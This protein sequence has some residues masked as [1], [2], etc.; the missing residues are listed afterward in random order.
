[1]DNIPNDIIP[2]IFNFIKL[3]TDKRQFLRTCKQINN[4]TK[5]LMIECENKFKIDNFKKRNKY[6]VEKFTLELCHDKYFNLIPETYLT[7]NNKI[8][9]S[10]LATFGNLQ[11]LQIAMKNGC[12]LYVQWVSNNF[13][14]Y[15][16]DIPK[17]TDFATIT[18]T[19]ALAAHNGHKHIIEFCI[20]NG[21][22]VNRL[23]Y[24]MAI[25]N[26]HLELANWILKILENN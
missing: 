9:V 10:T 7:P 26:K 8:I 15:I 16:T 19:C 14:R 13:Y 5:K 4:I 18:D 2:I 12:K 1:M 22:K 17:I 21:G 6:C 23:S 25:E 24:L 3:I 11:L 20:N